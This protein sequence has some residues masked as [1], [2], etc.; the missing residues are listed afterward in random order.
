MR[1]LVIEDEAETSN[2]ICKGLREA[3]YIVTAAATGPDGLDYAS[4]EDWE[5][6]RRAR[7]AA[8]ASGAR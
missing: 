5:L 4:S 3:G 2:Y 1:C 8:G 6:G 7:A